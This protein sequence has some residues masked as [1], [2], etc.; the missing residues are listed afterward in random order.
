MFGYIIF[1]KPELRFREYDDYR[2]CYCGICKSLKKKYGIR[3][4]ISLNYDAVFITLL[5]TGLYEP[6]NVCERRRCLVHP[7]KKHNTVSNIYSEYSA[8]MSLYLTYYKCMDD[9]KDDKKIFRLLY[10]S[11][12]KRKTK[13]ILKRYPGKCGR[14]TEELKKLSEYEKD[15]S[16]DIDKVSGCF[17][18]IMAEIYAY[19][20]D[21]WEKSLRK[22][23]FYIGKFVY[24]MDAY[25]DIE[26]DI[27][28]GSYNVLKGRYDE[29][30]SKES[31][32][33]DKEQEFMD[34][35]FRI[36]SMMMAECSKEFEKLPVI[37]HSG[38]LRNI[39]YSG[40]WCRFGEKCDKKEKQ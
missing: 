1:N 3:G 38:L 15:N 31:G 24:I 19:D 25:D 34:E 21:I 13:D 30:F 27:K 26:S 11:S 28:S 33:A 16:Y 32:S 17:G 2:A 7:F 5:L 9:W 22:I 6:E 40:V 18:R 35:C 23:G 12:L 37:M 39:L 14:I 29:V 20:N 36:L 10:A 4:Q 8:D